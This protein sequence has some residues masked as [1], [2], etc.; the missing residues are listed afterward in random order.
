[1]RNRKSAKKT[2][3]KAIKLNYSINILVGHEHANKYNTHIPLII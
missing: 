3:K 2:G 1:M